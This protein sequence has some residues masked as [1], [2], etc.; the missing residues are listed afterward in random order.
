MNSV[1]LRRAL[2]RPQPLGRPSN[3]DFERPPQGGLPLGLGILHPHASWVIVSP[4][5]V[6]G[7]I[8]THHAASLLTAGQHR[9]AERLANLMG[10][11]CLPPR[12]LRAGPM[13]GDGEAQRPVQ[14]SPAS[15]PAPISPATPSD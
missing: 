5:S 11:G 13:A 6:G 15:A 14:R 3:F 4:M 12:S 10:S 2:P 1:S 7:S 8:F 9:V